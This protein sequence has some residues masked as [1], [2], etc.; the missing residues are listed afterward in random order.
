MVLT[1]PKSSKDLNEIDEVVKKLVGYYDKENTN[2]VLLSEYGITDV[3]KPIHINRILRSEGLISIREERGLEL[4]DAGASKAFGVAD[5]QI[6]HIYLNDPTIE[7]KVKE[8]LK[9][10]EGI[11]RVLSHNEL[12]E[13][14]LN[15]EQVWRFAADS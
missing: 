13:A 10:I 11:D 4:L 14:H 12:E 5:H 1:F 6:A 9:G 7:S 8:L 2:I 15:H 3:S